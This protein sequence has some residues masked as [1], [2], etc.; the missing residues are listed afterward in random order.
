MP[1]E[2]GYVHV[3]TG[4]QLTILPGSRLAFGGEIHVYDGSLWAVGT[5][6]QPI[7]FTTANLNPAPGQWHGVI[8]ENARSP[9]PAGL[10]TSTLN[11]P[12]LRLAGITSA[13]TSI[14]ASASS[15]LP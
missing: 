11:T 7:S 15:T 13:L 2:V 9:A 5:P 14:P 1:L 6:S 4:A 3:T 10:N 12:G 8:F